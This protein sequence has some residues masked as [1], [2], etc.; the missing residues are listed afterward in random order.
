VFVAIACI[1]VAIIAGVWRLVL[2]TRQD[3]YA[4]AEL[5]QLEEGSDARE[6]QSEAVAGSRGRLWDRVR[7]LLHPPD[8]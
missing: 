1:V 3:A 2:K 6:R 4:R 7:D 5:D 8:S